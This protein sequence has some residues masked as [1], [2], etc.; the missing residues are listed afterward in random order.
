[1]D[2]DVQRTRKI[3]E[4]VNYLSN[5][6]QVTMVYKPITSQVVNHASKP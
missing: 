1:M 4:I 6:A 5:G 2:D 3:T